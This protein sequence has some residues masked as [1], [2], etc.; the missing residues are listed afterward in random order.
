[1]TFLL[2]SSGIH[3]IRIDRLQWNTVKRKW[4]GKW[5]TST[6]F[7]CVL[8]LT[9]VA[10]QY[11]RVTVPINPKA[12]DQAGLFFS[13]LFSCR[14]FFLA[15]CRTFATWKHVNPRLHWLCSQWSRAG[16]AQLQPPR[17][18]EKAGFPLSSKGTRKS[19]SD[20]IY[21]NAKFNQSCILLASAAGANV[22]DEFMP[23]LFAHHKE[24]IHHLVLIASCQVASLPNSFSRGLK[25]VFTSL[26]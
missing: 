21:M 24:F 5:C 10:R 17:L 14:V 11:P 1:M 9:I 26:L 4:A 18:V 20:N 23:Y 8:P 13:F 3:H 7:L 25:E 6:P 12:E 22:Q 16:T 19:V 2:N 15:A